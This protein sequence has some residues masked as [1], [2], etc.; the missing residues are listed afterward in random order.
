MGSRI[1]LGSTSEIPDNDFK[2]FQLDVIDIIVYKV[3][4]EFHAISPYCPHAGANLGRGPIDKKIITCP[5]HGYRFDVT[6]G[7]CL[8]DPDLNLAKFV[9]EIENNILYVLF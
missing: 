1:K 3:N 6:T 7:R 9:L 4:G 2:V 5:G 8:D